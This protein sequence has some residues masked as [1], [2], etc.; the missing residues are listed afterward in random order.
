VSNVTDYSCLRSLA[1]GEGTGDQN[2]AGARQDLG[3][4]DP[5]VHPKRS[6]P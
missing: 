3:P 6:R 5:L 2:D 4:A 1:N